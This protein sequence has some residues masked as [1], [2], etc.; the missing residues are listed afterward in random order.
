MRPHAA[1]DELVLHAEHQAADDF[2][3]DVLMHH[4]IALERGADALANGFKLVGR[5]FLGDGD[6]DF[7]LAELLVE[8]IVIGAGDG[9]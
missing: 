7:D 4:R 9:R 2:R 1:V 5:Q 6:V 3:I 8:Q